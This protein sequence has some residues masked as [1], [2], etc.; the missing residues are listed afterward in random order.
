[1][2]G[3]SGGGWTTTLCAAIDP[4]IERSYPVAG[5]HPNY[6]RV[7]KVNGKNSI[8]D[9]EQ[10]APEL[11]RVA[12]Y[13]ELYILGSYGQNR[14]QLQILNEFDTCCFFGTGY[15]TYEDI[16]KKRVKNLG[17]GS[18]DVFLDSSHQE[19]KISDQALQV[20]FKDLD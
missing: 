5:S 2:T 14:G 1:M 18:Y 4:R 15:T 8:G 13:L 10:Y 9:Y 16:V 17:K 6:L 20:I 7:T 11:Y 3:I 12:N 19:H